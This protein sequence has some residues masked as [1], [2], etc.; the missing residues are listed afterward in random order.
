MDIPTWTITFDA[1]E[2][3]MLLQAVLGDLPGWDEKSDMRRFMDDARN[4]LQ[5]GE[6]SLTGDRLEIEAVLN[7]A[8]TWFAIYLLSDG[9]KRL[10]GKEQETARK[11]A[12][13]ANQWVCKAAKVIDAA[14]KGHGVRKVVTPKPEPVKAGKRSKVAAGTMN[15]FGDD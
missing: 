10:S 11:Q 8:N 13:Y 9:F 7:A 6:L 4:R 2:S 14:P 3:R 15:L 5:R 1:A 12:A